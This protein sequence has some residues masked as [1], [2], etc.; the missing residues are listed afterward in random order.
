MKKIIS[1][2]FL[3]EEGRTFLKPN[4][5]GRFQVPVQGSRRVSYIEMRVKGI[6]Q[7]HDVR[8]CD[9][10]IT[11]EGGEKIRVYQA[12]E[13]SFMLT[14]PASIIDH[15]DEYSW[16]AEESITDDLG[17]YGFAWPEDATDW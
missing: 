17:Q 8:K 11:L 9:P 5:R 14:Y 6:V 3:T 4:Y 2:S 12:G 16:K 10:V 7:R 1:I 13:G 15:Y